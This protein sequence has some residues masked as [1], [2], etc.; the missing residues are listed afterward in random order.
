MSDTASNSG[1]TI[2]TLKRLNPAVLGD[3][4][5]ANTTGYLLMPHRNAEQLRNTMQTASDQ[6]TTASAPVSSDPP[7]TTVSADEAV[8]T[9]E[10]HAAAASHRVRTHTVRAGESLWQIARSN[11]VSVSTLQRLNHL[12]G[13]ELKPGQVLK[14]DAP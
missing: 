2:D 8:N 5:D 9:Q 14:L 6:Q 1:M 7:A 3:K 4:V 13:K 12:H 10:S 11:S